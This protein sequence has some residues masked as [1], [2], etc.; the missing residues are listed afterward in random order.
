M[1][2]K[3][4]A[5]TKC[6]P[7]RPSYPTE[8]PPKIPTSCSSGLCNKTNS[9]VQGRA[10]GDSK[11]KLTQTVFV[12][13]AP[14]PLSIEVEVAARRP[15]APVDA[16][17]SHMGREAACSATVVGADGVAAVGGEPNRAVGGAGNVPCSTLPV[18]GHRVCRDGGREGDDGGDGWKMH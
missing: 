1:A 6:K 11:G 12:H 17:L 13:K 5:F 9:S 3:S 14:F 10:D 8:C 4:P 16:N 7:P 15:H 2:L 18:R